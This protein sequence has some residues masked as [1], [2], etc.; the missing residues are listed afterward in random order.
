MTPV[1]TALM[2]EVARLRER[3]IQAAS[4]LMHFCDSTVFRGDRLACNNIAGEVLDFV[5]GAGSRLMDRGYAG[6]EHAAR[7]YLESGSRLLQAATGAPFDFRDNTIQGG[8]EDLAND[9]KEKLPV[10][11]GIGVAVGLGLLALFL[12]SRR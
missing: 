11:G 12:A 1:Q 6:E 2:A 10:V 4:Q 9:F 5:N 7:N 8:L 3:L